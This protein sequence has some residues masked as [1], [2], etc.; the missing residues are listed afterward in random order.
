MASS[1]LCQIL[2]ALWGMHSLC[3]I[4]H[5]LTLRDEVPSAW[6][7]SDKHGRSLPLLHSVRT[8]LLKAESDGRGDEDYTAMLAAIVSSEGARRAD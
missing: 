8:W 6:H 5:V 4:A 7:S 1:T 3:S 2:P